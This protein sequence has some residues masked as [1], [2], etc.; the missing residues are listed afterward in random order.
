MDI[1]KELVRIKRVRRDTRERELH[2][3]RRVWDEASLALRKAADAQ[4]ENT[5]A[6][7]AK[8]EA[9]D[10]DVMSRTVVVRDL[11]DLHL[12]FAALKEEARREE[13]AVE[14][15]RGLREERSREVADATGVWRAAA[16]A[17]DKFSDLHQQRTAESAVAAE[18]LADLE[19]E[20]HAPRRREDDMELE[21]QC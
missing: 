15:A 3:A 6:R 5:R 8:E 18:R 4:Q 2:R 11:D 12:E 19:L 1:I 9:L 20:E 10:R 21:E 17:F 16:Q 13:E 14:K 7:A